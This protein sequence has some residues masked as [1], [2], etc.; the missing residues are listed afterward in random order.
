MDPRF[1]G[2]DKWGGMTNVVGMI[3]GNK[4]LGAE[5]LQKMRRVE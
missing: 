4:L 2:D 1:R 5:L 3:C